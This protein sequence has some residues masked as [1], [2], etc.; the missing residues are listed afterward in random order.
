MRLA[1]LG[2]TGRIGQY[3]LSAALQSG[4]EVSALARRPDALAA[5]SG[6]TVLRGDASDGTA[7]ARLIEGTDAVLSALGPRGAKTPALLA[8]AARN[9]VDGMSR[10][11]VSRLICV[12][13]AGAFIQ[14]DPDS[15]LLVKL[16]LPRVLAGPFADVR[17]M[18]G[19]VAAS[20]LD[21]TMVRATRLAS[22]PGTGHYRVRPDYPPAG[23]GKIARA[24]VAHFM[25][26]CLAER[27]WVHGRPA[28][29]Y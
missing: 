27:S 22:S 28:L 21:W 20:D 18:E 23:G 6:L 17:E 4:H 29:A 15:G 9:I 16:I 26:A 13:A 5:A 12:S 25:A 8:T 11:G 1:L 10:A 19:I 14:G 2:G 3:I 24:D 7:V